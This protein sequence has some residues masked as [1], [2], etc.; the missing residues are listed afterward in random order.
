MIKI[1]L[2]GGAG[3]GKDTLAEYLFV[4]YKFARFAFADRMKYYYGL[5]QGWRGDY[6]E[7]I[8]KVNA[9][10]DREG[11]ISYGQAYRESYG[12]DVWIVD[13]FRH[14]NMFFDLFREDYYGIVIT[15]IRQQ[16]ELN[17][18]RFN[19]FTIVKVI[20]PVDVRIERLRE[21]GDKFDP[22]FLKHHTETFAYT[23]EADYFV[24]NGGK[25]INLAT[26]ADYIIRDL[27]H[28]G[29]GSG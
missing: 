28:R 11:L 6:T 22:S 3:A 23:V 2:V 16:N 20:A 24:E 26:Q 27:K 4:N 7:I 14:I 29:G 8:N 10:K 19:G 25:W 9:N 13:L 12:A 21:R 15:D 5:A 17:A 18:L 1:G